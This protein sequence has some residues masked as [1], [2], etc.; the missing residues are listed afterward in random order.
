MKIC[1]GRQDVKGLGCRQEDWDETWRE[2]AERQCTSSLRELVK[3]PAE[4]QAVVEGQQESVST[5]EVQPVLPLGT[6]RER[7]TSECLPSWSSMTAWKTCLRPSN[8][9][10]WV[11]INMTGV[12]SIN[13]T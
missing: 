3:P 11:L 6:G 8:R 13:S 10:P 2:R 5:D 4:G 1:S 9:G 7:V 12:V